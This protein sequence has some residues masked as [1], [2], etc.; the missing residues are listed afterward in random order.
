MQRLFLSRH[1]ETPQTRVGAPLHHYNAGLDMSIV[2]AVN[3]DNGANCS[4]LYE[5][6][7]MENEVSHSCA[8]IGSPCLRHCVHGAS[9][10]TSG[11]VG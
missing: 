11:V 9:T 7:A 4:S 3:T 1:I 10:G 2:L 5:A 8:C 6:A